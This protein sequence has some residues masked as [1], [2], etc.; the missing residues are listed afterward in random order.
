MGTKEKIQFEITN[1]IYKNGKTLKSEVTVNFPSKVI[2]MKAV[3]LL[4]KSN[5]NAE[6]K[7]VCKAK[8][9]LL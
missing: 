4:T 5:R 6:K 3:D 9:V 8:W 1:V 2:A 7:I